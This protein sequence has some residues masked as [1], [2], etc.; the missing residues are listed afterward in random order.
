MLVLLVVLG[1]TVFRS[2]DDDEDQND[3]SHHDAA[4]YAQ[5]LA[6][7]VSGFRRC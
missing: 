4:I 2:E 5:H 3:R 6:R 1:R 7:N